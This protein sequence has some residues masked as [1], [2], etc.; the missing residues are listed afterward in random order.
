M[1]TGPKE[2]KN[3]DG[4]F[5][6][7][8]G[9]GASK[10]CKWKYGGYYIAIAIKEFF[11]GK[12]KPKPKQGHDTFTSVAETI[13][14]NFNDSDRIQESLLKSTKELLHQQRML[15]DTHARRRL[16]RW[17][18]RVIAWY[19]IIVLIVV[20]LNSII[21]AIAN[22]EG[23]FISGGIMAAILTTT[24]VNIIGLGLII[25]KGHFPNNQKKDIE[26]KDK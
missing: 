18:T 12:T 17:A 14:A 2:L 9:I 8:V 6:E 15:E 7:Q 5:D 22:I 26:E 10:E 13:V 11:F 16:E 3:T 20:V 24:T 21:S 1:E 23:G 4:I 25:L 19:L